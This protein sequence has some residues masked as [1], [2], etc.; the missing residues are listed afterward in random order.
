MKSHSKSILVSCFAD[1]EVMTFAH[2]SL[3]YRPVDMD[4]QELS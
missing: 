3:S 1:T 2:D 4:M